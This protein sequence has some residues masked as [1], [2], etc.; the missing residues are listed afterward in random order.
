MNALQALLNRKAKV[1]SFLVR[2]TLTEADSYEAAVQ[3]LAETPLIAPVYFIVGGANVA[4]GAVITRDRMKA[5]DIWKL[6]PT[7]GRWFV[8]QTNYDRWEEPPT[9]D[10]R[11]TPATK[12]M[13]KFGQAGINAS[14][15]FQV[16]SVPLVLNDRTIHTVTMSAKQPEIYN[17]LIRQP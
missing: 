10:N 8:L 13:E 6:N 9:D 2:E 14:T 1:M 3:R 15:M 7:E 11:R 12:A 5:R 16:L 4:E 17:S